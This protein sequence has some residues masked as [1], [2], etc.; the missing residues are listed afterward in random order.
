MQ[1]QVVLVLGLFVAHGTLELWVDA[2]LEPDVP[3][4]A[5]QSGVRVAAPGA[6]VQRGR[7]SRRMI[8]PADR[9]RPQELY[10]EPAVEVSGTCM[11]TAGKTA[12]KQK[13]KKQKKKKPISTAG[14][15]IV[16]FGIIRIVQRTCT[17]TVFFFFKK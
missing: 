13:Q 4:Q 6:S 2:A 8:T 1:Q 7:L 5:V 12:Q 9:G 16:C 10:S 3:G 11:E 14:R 17:L 15:R